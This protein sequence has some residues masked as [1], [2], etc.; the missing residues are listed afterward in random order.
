MSYECS[1]CGEY[2]W[3]DD[4]STKYSGGGSGYIVCPECESSV[5]M[6]IGPVE[7]GILGELAEDEPLSRSSLTDRLS[8]EEEIVNKALRHLIDMHYIGTTPEWDYT[9]GTKGREYTSS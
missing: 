5:K 1:E 3:S 2:W 8:I 7:E 6:V 4:C 9:R